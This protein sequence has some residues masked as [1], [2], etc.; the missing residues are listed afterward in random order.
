MTDS[1]DIVVGVDGSPSSQ[2]AVRW[3][4]ETAARHRAP[5]RL[6]SAWTMS[7]SA[8]GG[9]GMPQWYFDDEQAKAEQR[10][11][12]AMRIAKDATS[13]DQLSVTS[14]L[15]PGPAS[16]IVIEGSKRAQMVVLGSRGL[17]EFTGGMLG[18][19]S[20]A[21]THHAHCP[22]AVIRE[23]PRPGAFSTPGSVVVGVDGS[24]SSEPAIGAAFVEAS[25]RRAELVAVRAWSDVSLPAATPE[26]NGLP[27][28][29]IEAA[30]GAVLAESLA[31]WEAQYPDVRVTK[32]VVQD[33]P[34]RHL[35]TYADTAA[36]LVVGSRGR[37]GFASLLLGSTS[38]ALLHTAECPL[39]IV[40]SASS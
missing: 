25:L 1:Q 6:L 32:V 7:V 19:V 22:V 2:S 4:A 35:L 16:R 12:E 38:T 34:V 28:E 24:A 13:G 17:G 27:W 5:L 21:V 29:S 39:L 31:G 33:R 40:R 14:Q 11:V 30:E 37:G 18:S 8:Y 26:G 9:V 3:A 20:A 10:L 15:M 36:L 23:W